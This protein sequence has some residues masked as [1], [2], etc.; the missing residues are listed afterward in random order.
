MKISKLNLVLAVGAT[1]LT[2]SVGGAYAATMVDNAVDIM[3]GPGANYHTIGKL[4]DNDN[5][6]VVRTSGEWCRISAPTTDDLDQTF[7]GE[8]VGQRLRPA[9]VREDHVVALSDRRFRDSCS[10]VSCA[11]EADCRHARFNAAR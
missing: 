4:Q 2:M 8:Q 3:S 9:R 11:D 7:A 6:S 10:D 1:A 5:V